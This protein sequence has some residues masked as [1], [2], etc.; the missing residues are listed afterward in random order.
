MCGGG[1][2]GGWHTHWGIMKEDTLEGDWTH[3]EHTFV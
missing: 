1:G 3:E 2:G